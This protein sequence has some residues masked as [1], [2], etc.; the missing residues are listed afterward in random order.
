MI[1][2]T[3]G[4]LSGYPGQVEILLLL[5]VL[6]SPALLVVAAITLQQRPPQLD[7]DLGR[8]RLQLHS[9]AAIW[10]AWLGLLGLASGLVIAEIMIFWPSD[11]PNAYT[12]PCSPIEGPCDPP[13][14]PWPLSSVVLA[15]ILLAA[16]R[17]WWHTREQLHPGEIVMD[18]QTLHVG[19]QQIGLSTIREAR[20]EA[21][22]WPC[23]HKTLILQTD[24]GE[25]RI[26]VDGERPD[27]L[28]SVLEH[29]ERQRRAAR[30][31]P[32]QPP[33]PASLAQLRAVGIER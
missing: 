11:L 15:G 31:S 21:W 33:I 9:S 28:A 29:L 20:I 17:S 12:L 19:A 3:L 14:T 22:G 24:P 13:G 30:C 27:A 10:L 25:L 16:G 8:M 1:R 4:G 26:A 18:T 6:S 5:S 32:P 23:Q 2:A 7:V